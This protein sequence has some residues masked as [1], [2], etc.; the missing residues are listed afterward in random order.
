[1]L[2]IR[3]VQGVSS[4]KLF[5]LSTFWIFTFLGLSL[6]YRIW[7]ARHCDALRVTV[8]KEVYA[9]GKTSS[10]TGW[11]VPSKPPQQVAMSSISRTGTEM[12]RQQMQTMSLYARNDGRQ[13]TASLGSSLPV[14]DT[15]AEPSRVAMPTSTH[16][17][18]P[19]PSQ[20]NPFILESQADGQVESASVAE[21]KTG[22]EGHQE[23]Y[24]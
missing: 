10:L 13:P 5:R 14:G 21:P 20:R 4:A 1:M 9:I 17:S 2:A 23:R 8:V 18:E 15:V 11:F 19:L 3:P 16:P 22:K 12:F 24:P 7:F 6:P